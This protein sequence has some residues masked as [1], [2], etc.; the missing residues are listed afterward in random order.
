EA[1]EPALGAVALVLLAVADPH[2]VALDDG[3]AVDGAAAVLELVAPHLLAGADLEGVDTAVAA[4]GQ[5]ETLAAD[6]GHDGD[7]VIG[8]LDAVVA[9]APPDD[10]AGLLVEGD[11][12]DH[13]DGQLAPAAG[14]HADDELVLVDDRRGDAAAVAGDAAELLGEGVLPEDVALL[15]VAVEDAG[16]G[17]GVDSACRGGGGP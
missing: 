13:A 7:G 16:G 11:Q 5:D 9:G 2:L 4:A 8:V 6:D 14:G 1:D 17:V 3:G 10:L 15:V 12:A